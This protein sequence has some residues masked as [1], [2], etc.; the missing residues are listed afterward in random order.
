MISPVEGTADRGY[1]SD[2]GKLAEIGK[3]Q[4]V[5]VGRMP[6]LLGLASVAVLI[7]CFTLAIQPWGH[8]FAIGGSI[9]FL[10]I[11]LASLAWRNHQ[12]GGP[13]IRDIFRQRPLASALKI[14]VM[15]IMWASYIALF[16][17]QQS[18]VVTSDNRLLVTVIHGT[19]LIMMTTIW[20]PGFLFGSARDR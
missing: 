1:F 10:P 2:V 3:T 16:W 14:V 6:T 8:W 11:W 9:L 15:L 7:V 20:T 17:I 4:S 5:G 18:D 13:P 19:V 12:D